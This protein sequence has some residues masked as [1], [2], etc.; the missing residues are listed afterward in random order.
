MARGS[1][2]FDTALQYAKEFEDFEKLFTMLYLHPD[3]VT[4]IPEGRNWSILH[5]VVFSGNTQFLGQVLAL[6]KKNPNFNPL[7]K[8]RDGKTILDVAKMRT[9]APEVEAYVE[10]LM[11]LDSLLTH[12]KLCHWKECMDIV[13]AHPSYLNEK[14]PYRRYYVIH[15]VACAGMQDVYEEFERIPNCQFACFLRTGDKQTVL[16]VAIEAKHPEFAEFIKKKY[17]MVLEE[18]DDHIP[19]PP[20]EDPKGSEDMKLVMVQN[21][22][23]STLEEEIFREPS[24]NL[25]R[26]QVIE[27]TAEKERDEI[28]RLQTASRTATASAKSEV[29]VEAL[30]EML[31]C[32]LTMKLFEDPGNKT[33]RSSQV[34]TY[35]CFLL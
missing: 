27:R 35:S 23:F 21:N 18:A 16:D 28:S 31:V 1:D 15:H 2:S 17:P 29:D 22:F 14:T 19:V 4:V 30:S 13:R 7:T 11:T 20:K 32:P 5:Q 24:K 9:D 34:T 26:K 12:A 33:D 6:Q 3:W 25:T 10:K 8:T